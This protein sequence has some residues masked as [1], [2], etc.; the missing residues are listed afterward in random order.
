MPAETKTAL[1][2]VAEATARARG[3][4]GFSYADLAQ[5][6][7]IRKASIHHHFPTK[8]LLARALLDRYT[9]QITTACALIDHQ[10]PTG[11]A[12]LSAL[13]GLYRDALQDGQSLCLCVAF[14]ASRDSLPADVIAQLATFRRRLTDWIATAFTLARQDG[15]VPHITDP[16]SEAAA[17]L[18]LLEGAQLSAR[19]SQSA[20]PFLRAT[21]Q[22]AQRL[23]G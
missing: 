9:G 6:V 18:A 3:F 22:F 2:D 20:A 15:T 1:L 23:C 16:A 12:R 14:S 17:L 4:D 21:D 5:Q 11:A 8:A 19:A 10:H 7:G 13:L